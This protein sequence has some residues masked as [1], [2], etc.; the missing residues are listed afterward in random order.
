MSKLEASQD[1][2]QMKETSFRTYVPPTKKPNVRISRSRVNDFD[3]YAHRPMKHPWKLLSAY[4]FM[5]QW[6]CEPLLLP[7]HYLHRN[8]TPRSAWTA[9]GAKLAN[10]KHYME[11]KVAAKPGV[12]YV[13]V[14]PSDDEYFLF[15]SDID[16]FCHAWV[17]VRKRRPD[18]V[19][20]E[21]LKL[22]SQ[23]KTATYN[24]QYCS[25]FFRAWTLQQGDITVPHLSLLGLNSSSLLEW[26][27]WQ[28]VQDL[29][30]AARRLTKKTLKTNCLP[31][32]TKFVGKP[33]GTSMSATTSSAPMQRGSLQDFC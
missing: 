25:L 5:Q 28:D 4:E 31:R 24:A 23:S 32:Q 22:P 33:H 9:A 19:V 26:H 1:A 14:E 17:L 21:G 11:G 12:D 16:P 15:P 13:A 2:S 18:V 10:S 30:R 29:P 7:T 3:A 8:V 20:I 27:A 6:R